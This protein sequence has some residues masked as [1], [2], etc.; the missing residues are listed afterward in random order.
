[1][2]AI[3][4]K[5]LTPILVSSIIIVTI[6]LL[7]NKKPKFLKK[8]YPKQ[9]QTPTL[10]NPLSNRMPYDDIDRS[11]A[12]D[13]NDVK[14]NITSKLFQ[15]FPTQNLNSYNKHMMER[16]FFSMPNTDIINKQKEFAS[17]LYG[18]PNKK[19]CKSN[20]EVCTGFQGNINS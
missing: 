16:Q 1:M 20:P 19:M 13:A 9:C 4:N 2:I 8:L 7:S 10:N 3:L 6:Y 5:D 18:A 15:Q 11:R 14:S 12:C 17:W